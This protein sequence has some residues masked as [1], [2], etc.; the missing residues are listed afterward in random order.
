MKF[1]SLARVRAHMSTGGTGLIL[2][3]AETKS[4]VEERISLCEVF[5]C[6]RTLEEVRYRAH[7]PPAGRRCNVG[8]SHRR[9]PGPRH[10]K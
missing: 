8:E 5:K 3:R 2:E 6:V 4:S 10:P 9:A 1:V 7:R